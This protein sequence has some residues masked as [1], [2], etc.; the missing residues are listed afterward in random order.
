VTEAAAPEAEGH[1][2]QKRALGSSFYAAMRIMPPGQREAMFEIYS[3]CRAV[4]DIADDGGPK[5]PRFAALDRWRSDIDALSRGEDRPGLAGMK[6][7]IARFGLKRED[8]HAIIDGMA[9]D[10]ERDIQAPD[11]ATFD[12]Y[13]DRVASAV[14]RL[15]VRVFGLGEEDGLALAEHLGR[16]LQTTNILRDL[17]EDAG[18]NRLYLPREFLADADIPAG[19][20]SEVLGH[21]KLPT[22]CTQ[23]AALAR[24]RFAKADAIMDAYPKRVVR[25]PRVMSEAYKSIL[26]ALETRGWTAPR[27]PVKLNKARLAAIVVRRVLF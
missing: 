13:C 17:D 11:F 20:P 24:D 8:F 16:A 15:S 3:F 6:T 5:P 2:A 22:V 12:L 23:L 14:G 18:L 26:A 9:M 10:V 27:V 21:P 25:T 19:P 4:D 7:A 1:T